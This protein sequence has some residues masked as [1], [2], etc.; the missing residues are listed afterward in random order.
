MKTSKRNKW[1]SDSTSLPSL[2]NNPYA[3]MHSKARTLVSV[4]SWGTRLPRVPS[5]RTRR[6]VR[7]LA[8]ALASKWS[9][10]IVCGKLW[11]NSTCRKRTE[12]VH[13]SGQASHCQLFQDEQDDNVSCP[14]SV[15]GIMIT[16]HNR[17]HEH[18]TMCPKEH[19]FRRLSREAGGPLSIGPHRDKSGRNSCH[20][21]RFKLR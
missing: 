17:P 5:R 4:L 8:A 15:F 3:H 11:R 16:G 21:R 7:A 9:Y 19:R 12:S 6:P 14:R 18:W 10:H 20:A 2:S 13:I 1:L